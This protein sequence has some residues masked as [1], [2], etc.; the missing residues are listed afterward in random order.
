MALPDLPADGLNPWGSTLRTAL[1]DISNRADQGVTA[2]GTAQ[3]ELD[4]VHDIVDANSTTLTSYGT[5]LTNVEN[6]NATKA[7]DSSVVKLSG[8]QT[9]SGVKTFNSAPLVPDN[10]FAIS[11]INGLQAALAAKAPLSSPAFTGAVTGID[12]SMVGLANVDNTTDLSKPISTATQ[13]ALD[14]K[15]NTA[16]L[17]TQI[18]THNHTGG[19]NGVNIPISAVT[20]L[21]TN[22][23]TLTTN[24]N[25]R[26]L[27]LKYSAAGSSSATLNTSMFSF[28]YFYMTRAGRLAYFYCVLTTKQAISV[29][30]TGNITNIEVARI[31]TTSEFSH[32][33]AGFTNATYGGMQYSLSSVGDGITVSGALYSIN[34]SDNAPAV[35]YITAM[36]PLPNNTLASGTDIS[37][38]GTFILD[39]SVG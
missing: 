31:K 29:Q 17:N 39:N 38:A 9:I 6:S 14:L 7:A 35:I 21:Q 3:A 10:S 2:A 32:V 4:G 37:L 25:S 30:S 33:W 16:D 28:P 11:K 22:I 19:V 20:N 1:I 5:R 24:A 23:N 18:Q 15:A 13:S 36:A 34:P 27:A 12:K 26:E 8:N